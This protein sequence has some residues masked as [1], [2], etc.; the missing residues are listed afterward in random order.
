MRTK[1]TILALLSFLLAFEGLRALAPIPVAGKLALDYV[2]HSGPARFALTLVDG[3]GNLRWR[4]GSGPDVTLQAPVSGGRYLLLLGG[5]GTNP[6][7]AELFLGSDTLFLRLRVDLLD[8]RG[9]RPLL[10]DLP[11]SSSPKALAAELAKLAERATVARSLPPDTV[12]PA[13]FS[14][15]YR[16]QL[17]SLF[18]PDLSAYA[19]DGLTP[20]FPSASSNLPV[21][22]G[23]PFVLQA[24]ASPGKEL[25][26]AWKRNGVAIEGKHGPS[27]SIVGDEALYSVSVSNPLGSDEKVFSTY[28]IQGRRFDVSSH[29]MWIDSDGALWAVGK[30]DK[31]QLGDGSALSYRSSPIRVVEKGVVSVAVRNNQSFFVKTDGSLWSM[32]ANQY[33]K[34]GGGPSE[35]RNLP[36]KIRGQG[37]LQV[38]AG[39]DFGMFVSRDGALWG[40][41]YNHHGQLGDGT[42][43]TRTSLVRIL[44]SGVAAIALGDSF[45]L[46]LK[47]DGSLWT[48]GGNQYG[49][50]G[51]GTTQSHNLP[52]QVV[53]AGVTSMVAATDHALFVKSD[54]SAWAM[55]NNANG[56]LG[57]GSKTDQ[58]N[59]V[60]VFATG[61]SRV[62]AGQKNSYFLKSDGTLWGCGGSSGGKLGPGQESDLL[63]P[64]LLAEGVEDLAAG[65]WQCLFKTTDGKL[66]G[67]GYN[68]EAQLTDPLGTYQSNPVRLFESGIEQ[69][70]A[71]S[72]HSFFIRNG[73]SLWGAGKDEGQFGPVQFAPGTRVSRPFQIIASGMSAVSSELRGSSVFL[74][75]DGTLHAMGSNY[76]GQLGTG[77]TDPVESLLQVGS[78]VVAVSSGYHTLYAKTDGSLWAMGANGKGQL[79]DGTTTDRLSAV[80]VV[81]A[82]VTEVAVGTS[83]SVFQKTDGSVWAMGA[84]GRI[85]DGGRIDR[86]LPVQIMSSGAV[87]ISAADGHSLV[88]KADG[89]LWGFGINLSNGKLGLGKM[90]FY[91]RYPMRIVEKGV[92]DASAGGNHSLFVKSDG[93]LWGMGSNEQGQLGLT[94]LSDQLFPRRILD[95]GVAQASAGLRHS[96]VRMQD[97]SV[98]VF[99]SDESGQLGLGRILHTAEPVLMADGLAPTLVRP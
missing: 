22:L 5:Q 20:R 87:S 69:A 64:I 18:S 44:E 9:L 81:D 43:Q 7:P 75:T 27:L 76:H 38:D 66:F 60:R 1:R 83:F 63:Q 77:S 24:P 28:A 29:S 68:A 58:W 61:V 94:D 86:S 78:G 40:F 14:P 6:L 59:P 67:L 41:G 99:G 92:L 35:D 49:Q 93:S 32:G 45:S 21:P 15:V 82:N 39:W 4:N 12:G 23:Q 10:P 96:L 51:D 88:C 34:L 31:G 17:T 89:S 30:N 98:L 91:P 72:K 53:S 25:A 97:G 79:G 80:R 50:L 70:V 65:R 71:G 90:S 8:G 19:L 36:Y 85:G 33:G 13:H 48:M 73:G 95:S 57:I 55:G 74:K 62:A 26:Y 3:A 84:N 42:T 37:V 46:I 52:I 47:T 54:G 2:N 16:N 56:Q 11:V